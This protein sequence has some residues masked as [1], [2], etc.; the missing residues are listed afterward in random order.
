MRLKEIMQEIRKMQFKEVSLGLSESRLIVFFIVGII[1]I[2]YVFF[3]EKKM[4]YSRTRFK[5]C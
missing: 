3:N 5:A 4:A 2:G 1:I